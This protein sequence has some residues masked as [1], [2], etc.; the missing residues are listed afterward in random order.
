MIDFLIRDNSKFIIPS[1]DDFINVGIDIGEFSVFGRELLLSCMIAGIR[2]KI[3]Y[4]DTVSINTIY[5]DGDT[6]RSKTA[7]EDNCEKLRKIRFL[8]LVLSPRDFILTEELADMFKATKLESGSS[9]AIILELG[10][11]ELAV[12]KRIINL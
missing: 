11:P 8:C 1:I 4:T 3:N 9:D 5:F 10:Y 7:I 6:S 2:N 12:T